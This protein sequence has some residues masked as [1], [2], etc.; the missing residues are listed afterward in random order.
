ME[1]TTHFTSS[2]YAGKLC[3]LLPTI[4]ITTSICS[5]I[6]LREEAMLVELIVSK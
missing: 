3:S 2:A 1:R 4:T 5:S 6:F